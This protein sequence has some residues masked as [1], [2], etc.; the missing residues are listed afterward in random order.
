MAISS[1]SLPSLR[2]KLQDTFARGQLIENQID[3]ESN[4]LFHFVI[5]YD[6]CDEFLR[7]FVRLLVVSEGILDLETIKP[8]AKGMHPIDIVLEQGKTNFIDILRQVYSY[9]EVWPLRDNS[10]FG[11]NAPTAFHYQ[12]WPIITPKSSSESHDSKPRRKSRSNSIVG[13]EYVDY[14]LMSSAYYER[15]QN[16]SF[17]HHYKLPAIFDDYFSDSDDRK[18]QCREVNLAISDRS[19]S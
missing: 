16:L 8:N 5:D 10:R 11:N 3:L 19:L 4:N 6:L 17:L 13:L 9:L 15:N 2:E 18:N 7:L 12:M 1:I 14:R